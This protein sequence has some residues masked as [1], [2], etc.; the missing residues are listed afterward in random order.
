VDSPASST[1]FQARI[2]ELS[3][4]NDDLKILLDTTDIAMV[5]LDTDLCV[6]TF[7]RAATEIITL[8]VA[9]SGRPVKYL[10]TTLV[11]TD[12]TELRCAREI[13]G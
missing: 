6:R 1:E 7:T 11:D 9:D 4:L 8:T 3:M 13:T 5:L 10:T 2:E 12:L